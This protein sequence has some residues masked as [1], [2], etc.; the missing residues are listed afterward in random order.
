VR[1]RLK[2]SRAAFPQHND[3]VNGAPP[4]P[5]ARQVDRNRLCLMPPRRP[6]R[7]PTRR[8][9]LRE[10][11]F[12]GGREIGRHRNGCADVAPSPCCPPCHASLHRRGC[13]LDRLNSNAAPAPQPRPAPH[14]K[15]FRFPPDRLVQAS[16]A[17]LAR[18]DRKHDEEHCRPC[19]FWPR[20][21]GSSLL[22]V[23]SEMTTRFGDDFNSALNQPALFPILFESFKSHAI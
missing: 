7:R 13:K 9:S 21:F 6:R 1:E 3:Y 14:G 2:T 23:V 8:R 11:F 4:C 16:K 15:L 18:R 17:H 10:R 20:N 12:G 22:Y 5:A 19:Y